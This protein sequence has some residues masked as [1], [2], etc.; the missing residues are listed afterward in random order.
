MD[1]EV[2]DYQITINLPVANV[3]GC[4]GSNAKTLGLQYLQFLDV[5]ASGGS[6]YETRVVNHGKDNLLILQNTIP[7]KESASHVWGRSQPLRRFLSYLIDNFR[8][9]E[10]FYE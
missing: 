10:P 7:D 5:G 8:P 3:P 2:G 1:G 9:V 4:I 6:P